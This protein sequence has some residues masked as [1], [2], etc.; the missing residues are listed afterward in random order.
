[1][2]W[3]SIVLAGAGCFGAGLVSGGWL[4]WVIETA[5]REMHAPQQERAAYNTGYRHAREEILGIPEEYPWI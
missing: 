5:T 3:L 1:M 4:L 2:N